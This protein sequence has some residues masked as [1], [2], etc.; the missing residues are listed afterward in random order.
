MCDT[1]VC[2]QST[3]HARSFV[4]ARLAWASQKCVVA[5]QDGVYALARPDNDVLRD[6][7]HLASVR[8]VHLSHEFVAPL[9]VRRYPVTQTGQ[10]DFYALLVANV[11]GWRARCPKLAEVWDAT[12]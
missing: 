2:S 9:P 1:I 12:V 6:L 3:R 10:G 5:Q 8:L 4:L 7:A 11:R